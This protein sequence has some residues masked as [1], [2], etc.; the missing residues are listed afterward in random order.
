MEF[1]LFSCVPCVL[2]TAK[3]QIVNLSGKKY[4]FVDQATLYR[5][6]TEA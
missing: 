6:L 2:H 3:R 4:T 1:R 5:K